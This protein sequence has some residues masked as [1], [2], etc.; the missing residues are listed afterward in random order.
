ML[1]LDEAV[2]QYYFLLAVKS[3]LYDQLHLVAAFLGAA[4]GGEVTLRSLQ[5]FLFQ[6][7]GQHTVTDIRHDLFQHVQADHNKCWEILRLH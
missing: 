6:H 3:Q 1:F 7:I 5:S 2:I 4:V